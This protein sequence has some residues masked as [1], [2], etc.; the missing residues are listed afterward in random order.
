MMQQ[1]AARRA[2][3]YTDEST[4]YEIYRAPYVSAPGLP[5]TTSGA[6]FWQVHGGL[7]DIPAA[8]DPFNKV[9]TKQRVTEALEKKWQFL[10]P[11]PDRD[12]R[13][14]FHCTSNPLRRLRSSTKVRET[15]WPKL[16]LSVVLDW[17]MNSTGQYADYILPVA[18]WYERTG[19]KWVAALSPYLTVTNEAV[20]PVGE[21]KTEWTLWVLLS[22]AI[23][24]RAKER[25]IS[26]IKGA[27]GEDVHL[28]RLADDLT[29]DGMFAEEADD[30]VAKTILELSTNAKGIEWESLKEK[31]FARFTGLGNTPMTIG[32]MC[33]V[34]AD[35]SITPFTFHKHGKVPYPTE[36]G[37]IQT[38]L[39]H[40]LYKEADEALPRHKDAPA[41]G[42]DYPLLTTGGKTRWSIHSA[43][44]DSET[45]LRLHRGEPFILLAPKDAAARQI[46]DHDWVEVFNDIGSFIVRAKTT[47]AVQPG[48]TLMYHAWENYQFPGKGDMNHVS[49]SPINP[50]ELAG[51]HPHLR[52]G[53]FMGQASSFDR[54]TRIDVRK[55]SDEHV[56]ELRKGEPV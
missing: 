41:I 28:D 4:I 15:L 19:H 5:P 34:P 18:A 6:L 8:E 12:P 13:I 52:S 11:A 20:K 46:Q 31:G 42:G 56:R 21:S 22:K 16:K 7:I 55:V 1:I 40:P 39:N 49:P 24:R 27:F 32:G 44:R 23:Q 50:V 38:Y 51:G 25:G 10:T 29:M 37:R 43:W 30:A 45:M 2:A 35:D 48:Q 17:R 47:P 3:G 26:T 36:T 53:Y 54:D 14:I 9:P 33:D